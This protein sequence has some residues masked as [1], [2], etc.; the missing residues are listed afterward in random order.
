MKLKNI[1]RDLVICRLIDGFVD[2][3]DAEKCIPDGRIPQYPPVEP[4][5]KNE[6]AEE[7]QPPEECPTE[8]C[9][10]IDDM[11]RPPQFDR[12]DPNVVRRTVTIP[13]SRKPSCP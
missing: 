3:L 11:I 5:Y 10:P 9:L 2:N 7:G 8:R 13:K 6:L 4:T 1:F 12:D